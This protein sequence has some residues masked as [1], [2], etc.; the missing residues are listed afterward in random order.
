MRLHR[1]FPWDPRAPAGS[2]GHALHVP[3]DRQGGGRHDNPGSYGAVYL[4]ES[5]HA[6]LAET[7]AHLRGQILEDADLERFGLRLA[8]VALEGRLE[9]KLC[10]LDDPRT[11]VRRRLRPSQVA[12]RDRD[13]TQTWAETIFLARPARAGIRWWSTIESS[14]MHVTLFDRAMGALA[15]AGEPEPLRAGH[16]VVREACRTLGIRAR[17]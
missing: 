8:V 7:L 15:I 2:S 3:R 6:A 16:P 13:V 5:A 17:A 10:D 11:L 14:W 1:V 4:S 9:G 12:T